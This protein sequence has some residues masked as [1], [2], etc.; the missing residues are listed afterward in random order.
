MSSNLIRVVG[1]LA[2]LIGVSVALMTMTHPV[3]AQS[4]PP[5]PAVKWGVYGVNDQPGSLDT[6]CTFRSAGP[7]LIRFRVYA[8]MGH[9]I[10]DKDHSKGHTE[11]N[12]DGTLKNP[13]KLVNNGLISEF[14]NLS[15]P[16]YDIDSPA[17]VDKVYL[18][19]TFITILNG[20]NN[21][22]T[23]LWGSGAQQ[24]PIPTKLLHFT[25]DPNLTTG[26]ENVIRIDIDTASPPGQDRWCM[27]VDWVSV[28]FGPAYPYVMVHGINAT[29]ADL[30]KNSELI[31]ALKDYGVHY[32]I[33]QNVGENDASKDNGPALNQE[34]A[35]YLGTLKADKVNVIA[36]SKG[37]LDTQYA[38]FLNPTQFKYF[39]LGTLSTPHL[40][41]PSA[42]AA[43]LREK[44]ADRYRAEG[45]DPDGA[46]A[47]YLNHPTAWSFLGSI[48]KLPKMPG[49]EDLTTASA[50]AA[51]LAGY[52]GGRGISGIFTI[53]AD[54]GPK[55]AREPT[56]DELDP[57]NGGIPLS[58]ANGGL[59][60]SYMLVCA[61]SQVVF[62][63]IE[64]T[65]EI[66]CYPNPSGLA[67][68]MEVTVRTLK[69]AATATDSP[70]LN[71]VVVPRYS[72]NPNWGTRIA[73]FDN[74]NHSEVL[75]KMVVD[76]VLKRT[77]PMR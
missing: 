63:G 67:S 32:R 9:W 53:G 36:H 14:L 55:C 15:M 33:A 41:T 74:A 18:N 58:P 27:A 72:A 13:S 37:G 56:N 39:S 1:R 22:W 24:V 77:A 21:T 23:E 12:N 51:L 60:D 50:Q 42:D 30:E 26:P 34:L 57:L 66:A 61:V 7:L 52:R 5:F 73:N 6:G 25:T 20:V 28:S 38:A 70:R 11:V 76:T 46:V 54:A 69:Y 3:L 8:T 35:T 47:A 29:A 40:G 68:C 71:D 48:G 19:D 4:A 10:D 16:I 59:K 44:D 64:E 65:K 62:A 2:S 45:V 75:N 17:E 43:M 31:G 49:L